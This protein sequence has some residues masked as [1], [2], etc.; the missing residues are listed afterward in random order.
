VKT[1]Y[2]ATIVGVGTEYGYYSTTAA[3]ILALY[4]HTAAR[5]YFAY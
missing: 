1:L 2:P 4:L 5:T 3:L